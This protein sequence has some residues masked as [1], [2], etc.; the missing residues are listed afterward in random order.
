MCDSAADNFIQSCIKL[1]VRDE[2]P[3]LIS[4]VMN[5]KR[6]VIMAK[7]GSADVPQI[8]FLNWSAPSAIAVPYQRAQTALLA[9][10]L[11]DHMG[12]VACCL[13][14]V[15]SYTRGKLHL[16]ET[17]MIHELSAGNHNLDCC[18]SMLFSDQV[19]ERDERPMVYPG[20]LVFPSPAPIKTH[21]FF[22]C[23][24]RKNR[25]TTAVKQLAT[26]QLKHVED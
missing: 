21:P 11:S 18:F 23:D 12:S 14:P 1:V 10:G 2:P 5:Y 22:G 25:I 7:V 20:R 24:L 13:N 8:V 26:K 15:F 16:E 17:R 3:K 19:D 9:W 6:D 4:Q